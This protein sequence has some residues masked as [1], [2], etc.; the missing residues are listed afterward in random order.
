MTG[1]GNVFF[2]VCQFSKIQ[3]QNKRLRADKKLRVLT[4]YREDLLT[5]LHTN[6]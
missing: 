5:N 1:V 2:P 4:Y 6:Q 3:S